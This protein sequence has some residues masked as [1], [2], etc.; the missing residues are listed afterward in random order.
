MLKDVILTQKQEFNHLI[1]RPY[2][3]R[4]QTN[5]AL[6][7]LNKD[8]IKVVLGPRRAGKSVFLRSFS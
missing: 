6:K 8:I 1:K 5:Y 7:F 4:E 2:I 3:I